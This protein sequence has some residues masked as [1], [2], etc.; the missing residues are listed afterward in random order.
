[1]FAD[2]GGGFDGFGAMGAGFDVA[3]DGALGG[4][5]DGRAVGHDQGGD[6][7]DERAEQDG[8]Q[9]KTKPGA[10]FV[11]GDDGGEDAQAKP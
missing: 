1:M 3:I 11:A 8:Q 4:V 10:A 2:D 5:G 6:D 9:E 7:A